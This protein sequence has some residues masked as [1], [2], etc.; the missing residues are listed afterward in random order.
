MKKKWYRSKWVYFAL[1]LILGIMIGVVLN[2]LFDVING[3]ESWKTFLYYLGWTLLCTMNWMLSWD[4]IEL[5]KK[6]EK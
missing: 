4:K 6:E 2:C 1:T 5:V 3:I